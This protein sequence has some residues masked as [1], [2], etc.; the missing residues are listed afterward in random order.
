MMGAAFSVSCSAG[1]S[2][3]YGG[4]FGL[5][6]FVASGCEHEIN[7]RTLHSLDS[8]LVHSRQAELFET[9]FFRN[10]IQQF[11]HYRTRIIVDFMSYEHLL[12]Q[13]Q[14]PCF[15]LSKQDIIY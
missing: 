7:T 12:L 14:L 13:L 2:I 6:C 5:L 1:M 8:K 11:F 3:T 15:P 10:Y 4:C 9:C